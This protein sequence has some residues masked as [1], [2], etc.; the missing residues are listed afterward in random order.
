MYLK[1][2]DAVSLTPWIYNIYIIKKEL[3]HMLD[4]YPI[5][6][7]SNLYWLLKAVPANL[8]QDK[9]LTLIQPRWKTFDIDH[10]LVVI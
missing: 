5:W 8:S 3:D 10:F 9:T 4:S 6:S 2:S 1:R 7:V